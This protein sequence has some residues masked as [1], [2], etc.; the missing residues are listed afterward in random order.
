MDFSET[1]EQRLI[2]QTVREFCQREILPNV[3]ENDRAG[4]FPRQLV[5]KMGQLGILGGPVS[6]DYG[7]QGYDYI[8]H[9][10]IT[11][12]I[13]AADSGMR[14]C[15]SVQVSLVALTIERY[16]T[17][18][19]KR[20]YLPLL[21]RGEW[22]GCFG[23]TEPNAGSDAANQQTRAVRNGDEWTLNGSKTWITNGGVAE[24]ALVFAQTDPQRGA[25]GITAFLLERA[26]HGFE[27]KDIDGKLGLRTSNTGELSFRDV[28]VP[29]EQ[30]LGE[31]GQG[32]SIA[33]RALD[34]GRYS[35]AAGS[36]GISNA[37]IEA[38]TGYA[39]QRQAFGRPIGGF[40]L[41]QEMIAEM[42]VERDAGRLLVYRAGWKKNQGDPA[43]L[44]T[45]VAKLYATEAAQ[46][47]ANWAI[48]VH[49]GYGYSDEYPV[50]R[51]MRDARVNT[52]YEGTSQIQKL[53][54]G[55]EVLGISAFE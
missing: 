20:R 29:D 7:G 17:E 33:M 2:R 44:E 10:I 50:E 9:A 37:C 38:S 43:H 11:E 41:V 52:L 25:K 15:L 19:Q 26:K 51:Y 14:S 13:G 49:G 22:L 53:I 34:A 30:R 46:R 47:H 4:R 18:Q 36:V 40:Q 54:I 35:V 39:R 32:F 21:T 28:R 5:P 12:E 16:G 45:S 42:V 3:R 8:T 23:L 27:S 31:V 48:Q 24:L 6:P 1:E 55:R